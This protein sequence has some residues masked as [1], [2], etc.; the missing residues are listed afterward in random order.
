M[1]APCSALPAPAP[2]LRKGTKPVPK[3]FFRNRRNSQKAWKDGW[4]SPFG[5]APGSA[6]ENPPTK[7]HQKDAQQP[8]GLGSQESD[9]RAAADFAGPTGLVPNPAVKTHVTGTP[10]EYQ[11]PCSLLL[12]CGWPRKHPATGRKPAPEGHA[13]SDP[14]YTKRPE[15]ANPERQ[16]VDL[17]LSGTGGGGNNG[18]CAVRVGFLV[19]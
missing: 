4:G 8:H 14:V 12:P 13:V 16:R 7:R 5:P 3:G 17:G 2:P 10:P 18:D 11:N 6:G 1:R 19:R 15:Q 9:G